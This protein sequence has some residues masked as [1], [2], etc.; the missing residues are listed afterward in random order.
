MPSRSS[1]R[2]KWLPAY[3]HVQQGRPIRPRPADRRAELLLGLHTLG[4][5]V[6]GACHRGVI[7]ELEPRPH[8]LAMR[9]ALINT[10][11]G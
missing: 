7:A 4:M 3:H 8:H 6:E 9:D 11:E 5:H 10:R 2:T 1:H